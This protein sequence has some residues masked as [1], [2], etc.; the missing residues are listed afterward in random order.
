MLGS[1][2]AEKERERRWRGVKEWRSEGVE[3]WR[4]QGRESPSE[5]RGGVEGGTR[6][7]SFN[8]V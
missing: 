3:E 2:A 4:R 1:P 6:G 5:K 7:W 8:S